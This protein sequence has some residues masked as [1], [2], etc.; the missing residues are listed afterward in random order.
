MGA[1]AAGVPL[2]VA[3]AAALYFVLVFL[4]GLALGPIRVIWV[5]PVLGQTL[6]VLLEAPLLLAIMA[7]AAPRA[8]RWAA[9]CGAGW[10]SHLSVGLASTQSPSS[11]LRWR[12]WPR[13]CSADPRELIAVKARS[14][15]RGYAGLSL[16]GGRRGQRA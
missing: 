12:R 4:V 14:P 5:E 11:R 8:V 3:K 10:F 9:L 7:I 13:S 16:H 1:A 2:R 15:A 6:A